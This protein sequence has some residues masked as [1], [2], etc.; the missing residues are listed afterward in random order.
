MNQ[1]N[2]KDR[3]D[4]LPDV[5]I[6]D[7]EGP[8]DLLLHLIKDA[9][10]DIYDIQISKITS[11]YL[12]YLHVS[13]ELKLDIAGEY[14]VMAATLM[15]IK[16]KMLLPTEFSPETEGDENDDPRTDL[17]NQLIEYQKFQQ[18]ARQLKVQENE[19]QAYYT[20]EEAAV[21]KGMQLAHLAPG[22][23]IE[24][25]QQAFQKVLVKQE[26]A[27]P[28]HRTVTEDQL[29]IGDQTKLIKKILAHHPQGIAFEELF[30][31]NYS[32]PKVVVTF[33]AM[34]ELVKKKQLTFQQES[35]L[36]SIKLF[37]LGD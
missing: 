11:Q 25:L 23:T 35:E 32:I 16:S 18:A 17:V 4:Q 30:Q 33:M 27:Q 3:L 8:L 34:L 24:A 20:R 12:A 14:L 19:R 15:R 21:P 9:E 10:M 29:S 31:Q 1:I 7:F 13:Q 37:N 22:L 6:N 2:K 26:N 28:I 36:G 5:K